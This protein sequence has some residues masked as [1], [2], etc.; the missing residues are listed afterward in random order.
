[1]GGAFF[2]QLKEQSGGDGDVVVNYTDGFRMRMIERLAGP[3]AVSAQSLAKEVG[4]SQATLSRWLLKASTLSSMGS[5]KNERRG[6]AQGPRNWSGVEKL[7][8]VLEA[9]SIPDAELGEFLRKKGIHEADLKAWREVVTKSAADALEGGGKAAKTSAAAERR[10]KD[11]EQDL[12]KKDK[13]LKAVN[14]L[15]ELQKKVREIWG[16]AEEPTGPRSES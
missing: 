12:A 5:N 1:M 16:D 9:A 15:L 10:I 13:R 4:V 6:G 3:E 8:V 11:L 2:H 14:A 7:H